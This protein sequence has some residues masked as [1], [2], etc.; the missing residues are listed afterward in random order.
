MAASR[1][2]KRRRR[3]ADKTGRG[4]GQW[5]ELHYG[6]LHHAAWRDLSGP[7]VKVW[8]ELRSRFNGGNNGKLILSL[9]E[10][11]ELLH[12]SK[13]TVQR[14]FAELEQAGFIVLV[15]EGDWYGRRAQEWRCT[16]IPCE[17][18]PATRDWQHRQ[19]AARSGEAKKQD[20]VPRRDSCGPD[21]TA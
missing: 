15:T 12:L 14:A 2:G 21:G 20:T 5:I 16:D 3:P 9:R 19:A 1:T 10:A 18:A 4:G 7:A 17:G 11:A 6:M 13:S 8:M